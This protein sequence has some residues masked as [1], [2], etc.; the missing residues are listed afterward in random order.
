M[1]ISGLAYNLCASLGYEAEDR[2]ANVL[3]PKLQPLNLA[4]LNIHQYSTAMFFESDMYN[5]TISRI[6]T[7][8][9]ITFVY[10]R[11]LYIFN[12]HM[13][14]Y[15]TDSFHSH[16]RCIITSRIAYIYLTFF[17][18]LQSNMTANRFCLHASHFQ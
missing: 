8:Y 1:A 12:G 16:I 11:I 10:I 13:I 14:W 7:F 15:A 4:V 6:Y 2:Q 17:F 5:Y 18:T 9:N 3:S